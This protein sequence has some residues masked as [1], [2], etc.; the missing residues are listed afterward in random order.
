MDELTLLRNTRDEP[1]AP[2]TEVMARGR[3]ALASRIDGETPVVPFPH[4]GEKTMFPPAPVPRRRRAITLAGFSVLGAASLTVALV[5]VD[6]LGLT[7]WNSGADPAAASVLH[8]AASSAMTVSDPVVSPGQYLSVRTDGTF[9]LVGTLEE[10]AERI[11]ASG[12]ETHPSDDVSLIERYHDE[13]FV[14]ADRADDWVWIQCAREPFQTFDARSEAFAAQQAA[15]AERD[16]S[17]V[18]RWFPGGYT[19]GETAFGGYLSDAGMS[20]DYDALPRDPE[21][22]LSTIYEVN[23]DSGQSRDG[24]AFDW[25]TSALERG[26]APAEVRAALYKAVALIPGVEITDQQATL[27]GTTGVA[28]GRLE[29]ADTTRHDIIIDPDTGQYIGEREV[30]LAAYA[31]FPAGTT[32]SWTAVTTS[33][34]DAVPTDTATCGT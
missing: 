7:G 6:V 23:G 8:S 34:V 24:Q 31:S 18:I 29:H 27:N 16:D 21:E 4:S 2:S 28:F 32:T 12:G 5:A 14:P 3:A 9:S 13:L 30:A 1:I 17:P 15:N 33:V 10:D 25:I 11:R 20:A 22:L 19:P 26:T